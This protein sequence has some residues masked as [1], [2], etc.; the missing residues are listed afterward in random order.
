MNVVNVS[1]RGA[2]ALGPDVVCDGFIKGVPIRVQT[3][4]HK[5]HM[6]G[7][8]SSKG[9]QTIIMSE[10][11]R[12]LLAVE[13]D[14]DIPVRSNIR[15][16]PPGHWRKVAGVEIQLLPSEHMLG[17]VQ[18]A[19]MLK[20]GTKLAYSGD[21]NWPLQHIPETDILVVDSTYGSPA[22]K[23]TYRREDAESRFVQ[24]V[25]D[26]LR[27]G[28]VHIRAHR[29]TLERTLELLDDVTTA[30]VV[31]SHRLWGELDVYRRFGYAIGSV[32]RLDSDEGEHAV[33]GGQYIHL[34]GMG[35]P[36]IFGISDGASIT[37]SVYMTDPK[38]PVLE[39]S[40]RSYRVAISGHADFEETLEYIAATRATSVITDNS[41]GGHAVELA[42]EVR[43][44]LGIDAYPSHGE[45]TR[46]WGQ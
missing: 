19:V 16:M 24:L 35:D 10:A 21:F 42:M 14:A 38:D 17:A 29:G 40:S 15:A 27:N 45:P 43:A 37:L 1:A 8:E 26:R 13:F 39:Y 30:P 28:P 25:L 3:H 33:A 7:F 9:F 22:C 5:D 41:R 20:N 36:S 31:A 2:I 46:Y 34:H 12:E 44:R 32:L 6:G 4:V 11:T 18:V 23:R